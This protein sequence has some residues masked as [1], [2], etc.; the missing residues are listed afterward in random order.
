MGTSV[1]RLNPQIYILSLLQEAALEL[2]QVKNLEHC[3]PYFKNPFKDD[4][5]EQNTIVGIAYPIQGG[6]VV[7]SFDWELDQPL[8]VV[9]SIKLMV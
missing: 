5:I 2:N 9:I 7:C 4:E 1:E 8:F 6:P 3:L